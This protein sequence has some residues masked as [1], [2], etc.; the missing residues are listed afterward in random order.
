M[1]K[2]LTYISGESVSSG[3]CDKL[4]D[5]AGN[6]LLS[7]YIAFDK[8]SQVGLEALVVNNKFFMLKNDISCTY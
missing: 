8:D 4:L 2:N 3:H 6:A 1:K 5:C 7:N